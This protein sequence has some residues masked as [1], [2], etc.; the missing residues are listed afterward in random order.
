MCQVAGAFRFNCAPVPLPGFEGLADDSGVPRH[1]SK[2][3]SR[4]GLLLLCTGPA[5]T[6]PDVY[7]HD[8]TLS[9]AQNACIW[10]GRL[11][12][13]IELMGALR[14][15][16]P[17]AETPAALALALYETGGGPALRHLIGDWSLVIWDVRERSVL[18]SSDYAGVRPLYYFYRADL[19]LWSSNLGELVA[20]ARA[21][22][23]NDN[24]VAKFLIQGAT[25]TE[26]PYRGIYRVPPG[27]VVRACQGRLLVTR[28]WQ[29]PVH[30]VN[31]R[32]HDAEYEDQ[33]RTLFR[34]AVASRIDRPGT[35]CAELSGGLDSSSVVCMAA[36]LIAEQAVRATALVTVT[37]RHAACSDPPFQQA[38]ERVCQVPHMHVSAEHCRAAA[39]G[40]V[41][42]VAPM[43]WEAR[44]TEVARRMELMKA[45]MLLT[46]QGG[47]LVMGNFLDDSEQAA[48]YLC[49]GRFLSAATE[50]YRWSRSLQVPVWAILWAMVKASVS[51]QPGTYNSDFAPSHSDGV[52]HGG[53]TRSDVSKAHRVRR[54]GRHPNTLKAG[55]KAGTPQTRVGSRESSPG[56]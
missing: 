40:L 4:P 21:T 22:E 42:K 34:Q 6:Q 39:A 9:R 47:D 41:G 52:A 48:D 2:S 17:R 25:G 46:G 3:Y 43:L 18:L 19:L 33:F 30:E 14:V 28:F 11:D 50:A 56:R 31:R 35:V 8:L 10:E 51:P 49:E 12:N 1:E 37:Y 45:D 29:P 24:Y 16:G 5:D 13:R 23:I 27:C 32:T 53:L 26:T 15:N 55:D 38:V 44:F 7:G 20:A 54:R 36:R